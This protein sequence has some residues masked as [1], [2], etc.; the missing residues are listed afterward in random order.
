M[1]E[2][3]HGSPVAEKHLRAATDQGP[4]ICHPFAMPRRRFVTWSSR[5]AVAGTSWNGSSHWLQIPFHFHTELF[6]LK[7]FERRSV[8]GGSSRFGQ[9]KKIGKRE[10][11][12]DEREG[13]AG[14]SRR[15]VDR[16]IVVL[17]VASS[18]NVVEMAQGRGWKARRAARSWPGNRRLAAARKLLSSSQSAWLGAN[19]LLGLENPHLAREPPSRC[20]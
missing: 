20:P 14:F 17:L 13:V 1:V 9:E 5:S 3:S 19:S 2:A 15:V 7:R 16:K 6:P 4:R 8:T 11:R 18:R 12:R 10:L